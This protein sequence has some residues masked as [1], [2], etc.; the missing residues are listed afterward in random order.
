MTSGAA[1]SWAAASG[2][3]SLQIAQ[4]QASTDATLFG[5]AT[6]TASDL[7][8]LAPAAAALQL[9][10]DPGLLAGLTQWDGS[11]TPGSQ[12]TL[13]PAETPPAVPPTQWSFDPFD[14]STWGSTAASTGTTLD[15]SA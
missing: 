9:Y 12:R 11:Q 5:A 13:A 15:A 10:Q 3:A 7:A 6:G 8:S 2:S 1:A 14:Q 4:A